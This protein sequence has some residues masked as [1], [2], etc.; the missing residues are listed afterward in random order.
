MHRGQ[1]IPLNHI[2]RNHDGILVV[3]TFPRHEGN[4][5]VAAES[6]FAALSSIA[7]GKN[8]SLFYSLAL[9]NGWFQSDGRALV[10]SSVNRKLVD[11]LFRR[12]ADEFLVISHVVFYSY[13]VSI[14]ICHQAFAFSPDL[15][16]GIQADSFLKAGAHDRSLWVEERNCLTHHVGAHERAVCVIVLQ[17]W[18]EGGS[19]RCHLVRSHVHVVNFFLR[20]YREVGFQA[21]LDSV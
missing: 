19:D 7:F 13:L 2:L 10:S 1:D 14:D 20:N 17:E 8:L 15:S 9:A 6:Q 18:D 5:Q 3:I 11:C 12:E 4:H 21:A 16:P